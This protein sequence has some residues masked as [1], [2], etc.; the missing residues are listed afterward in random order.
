MIQSERKTKDQKYF[1]QIDFLFTTLYFMKL[2]K[3][4]FREQIH[5][6]ISDK[7]L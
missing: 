4:I 6:P 3:F 5:I 7:I 2:N 1:L